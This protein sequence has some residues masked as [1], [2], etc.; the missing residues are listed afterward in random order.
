M[1]MGLR[2]L[3][4]V[5]GGVETHVEKL[6]PRLSDMGCEVE[7]LARQ[8]YQPADIGASWRGVR[9]T[10]IWSPTSQSLEAVVHSL[11]CVL[12]AGLISRPDIL[13]IQAIGPSIVTPLARLFGLTVVVTHHGPDYAR[14]K[15]G[16]LAKL[17]LRLGETLGMRMSH[18]RVA[19]SPVIRD[20]ISQA[21][22]RDA[23][24]IP[25]G[26]DRPT[27]PVDDAS[28][29]VPFGLTP[30]KYVLIVSRLV[31]EKR[32]LDLINAFLQAKLPEDWKLVIVGGADHDTPYVADIRRQAALHDN[33]VMTGVQ[34]GATLEQLYAHASMFV[35]PSSHEGLP[36]A[37]L[38]AMSFNLPVLVSDIAPNKAVGLPA[39]CYFPLGN[40][41]A[42]ARRMHHVSMDLPQALRQAQ[43][44]STELMPRF[45]WHAIA[46]QTSD[47]YH[48]TLA[49]GQAYAS[50]STLTP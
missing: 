40:V 5:Q 11:L 44:T 7:V 18:Q 13:H 33:I 46:Q 3:P 2:G 50:R 43:D 1:F 45:N 25:N 27:L 41:A 15:W 38:E 28:Q 23:A 14:Q 17:A 31:P 37:L 34:T 9:I 21:H 29:L 30:R 4:H 6:A 42:A 36:I 47:L 22:G 24:L 12:Y 49:R 16:R 20:L 35:L 32:H 39:S 48:Q 8:A 26:V 10:R 19:I